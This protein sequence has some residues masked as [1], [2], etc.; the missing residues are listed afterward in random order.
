MAA[1]T[2]ESKVAAQGSR[3]ANAGGDF[4]NNASSIRGSSLQAGGEEKAQ[5]ADVLEKELQ[6]L[7]SRLSSLEMEMDNDEKG[8][9][10]G[11]TDG[12]VGEGEGEDL[13]EIGGGGSESAAAL[14]M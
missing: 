2:A 6:S 13:E 5:A 11:A 12:E 9:G 8:F 3:G 1:A 10:L 4:T 14:G 7:K